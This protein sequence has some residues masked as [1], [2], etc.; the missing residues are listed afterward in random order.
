MPT[1][2]ATGSAYDSPAQAGYAVTGSHF[3]GV[4]AHITLPNA[5]LFAR[6]LGMVEFGVQLWGN[7]TVVDVGVVAC[8]DYSC[9]P[10]GKPVVRDYRPIFRIFSR[11]TGAPICSAAL[12]N[13][14]SPSS[15]G[16][17]TPG[18]ALGRACISRLATL[19]A[20]PKG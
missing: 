5:S 19:W 6:E 3:V 14:P 17:R 15:V 12:G 7:S 13:C 9:K 16:G 1:P 2:R 4:G 10:G 20:T 11:K 8:T 18:S